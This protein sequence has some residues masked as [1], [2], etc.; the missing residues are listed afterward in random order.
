MVSAVDS[1]Q[2]LSTLLFAIR[3][4]RHC[5]ASRLAVLA[6]DGA[7]DMP[8][9]VSDL[10]SLFYISLLSATYLSDDR[11]CTLSAKMCRWEL[12]SRVAYFAAS[13]HLILLLFHDYTLIQQHHCLVWEVHQRCM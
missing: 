12:D 10:L 9:A 2:A 5:Y 11:T 8:I 4:V 6:K 1:I 3:T 13:F 7:D